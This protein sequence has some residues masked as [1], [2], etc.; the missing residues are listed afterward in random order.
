MLYQIYNSR[1]IVFEFKNYNNEITQDEVYST[2]RYLYKEALRTVAIVISRYKMDT[3]AKKTAEGILRTEKN[4]ILNLSENDLITMLKCKKENP[5][6]DIC[7]EYM[8]NLFDDF[9]ICL[10]K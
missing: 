1:Y 3:N 6:K 10:A 2:N 7:S 8:E 5:N 9:L 4:L